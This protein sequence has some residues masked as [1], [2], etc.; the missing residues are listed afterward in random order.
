[1][2]R[3]VRRVS[4]DWR[5]PRRA[6][7]GRFCPLFDLDFETAAQQWKDGLLAWERRD[8]AYFEFNAPHQFD[9][10]GE[11]W[12]FASEPPVRDRYRPKWS[13]A[14]RTHFQ[15]YES[16][17]EGTPISPV[18]ESPESLAR[19]LTDNRANAGAGG[20]ATYEEWLSVCLGKPAP[21][22]VVCNDCIASGISVAQKQT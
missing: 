4:Q 22:I 16:V 7:D 8:A 13:D 15:M 19:W 12:E 9:E 14:E 17:S 20:F 21:T 1:M 10:F 6:E 3:E 5:H 18:M 2:G 11:Y